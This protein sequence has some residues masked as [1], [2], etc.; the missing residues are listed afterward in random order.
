MCKF[1]YYTE[2]PYCAYPNILTYLLCC[3]IN[4]CGLKVEEADASQSSEYVKQ[5][6]DLT[7]KLSEAS[8]LIAQLQQQVTNHC[9]VHVTVAL[10]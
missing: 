10:L 3:I 8:S 4:V 9:Y 1:A 7:V 2:I 6:D 5:I